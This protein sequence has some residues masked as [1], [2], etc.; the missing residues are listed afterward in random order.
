MAFG[1]YVEYINKVQTSRN[2]YWCVTWRPDEGSNRWETY[3]SQDKTFYFVI[4][5]NRDEKTD[6]FYLSALQILKNNSN[7]VLT[8][9]RNDGDTTYTLE[10]LFKIYPQL[11]NNMDKFISVPFTK[12][13][14][15]IKNKISLINETPGDENEFKRQ[16]RPIKLTYINMGNPL[17][18]INSWDSM[19][20]G[21][22]STYIV[23]T[24]P[25][26]FIERFS[27]LNM[28]LTFKKS[29]ND[30]KLLQ[31]NGVSL[32]MLMDQYVKDTFMVAR[33]SIDNPNIRIYQ[34]KRDKK[35]GIYHASYGDFYR[36]NN[37]IYGPDY[38][39]LSMDVYVDDEGNDYMV[40]IF[41]KTGTEDPSSFYAISPVNDTNKKG[42]THLL[43]NSAWLSLQSKL[44]KKEDQ[45]D[46]LFKDIPKLDP[47]TDTDI[48]EKREL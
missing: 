11:Q 7:V 33:I 1:F 22:R 20:Q 3:R 31:N 43:S 6:R 8:S 23:L 28:I 47:E 35:F 15:A 44:E 27:N 45:E 16:E 18:S 12:D 39:E 30:V 40:E 9:V 46:D 48:K 19:D 42:S 38:N 29:P 32:G 13:E 24:T 34:S 17:T 4:D 2:A 41:S 26:N 25:N 21:L 10:E 14:L 37:T 36:L 5:S